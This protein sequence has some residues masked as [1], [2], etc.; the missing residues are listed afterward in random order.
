MEPL[1]VLPGAGFE[2]WGQVLFQGV[3]FVIVGFAMVEAIAMAT[4]AN[5]R[6]RLLAEMRRALPWAAGLAAAQLAAF[7]LALTDSNF[8]MLGRFA[9]VYLAF[10]VLFPVLWAAGKVWGD[11]EGIPV[12]A[13]AW[14]DRK[15]LAI[16]AAIALAGLVLNIVLLILVDVRVGESVREM[17]DGISPLGLSLLAIWLILNAP[18]ME[19]LLMRHYLVARIAASRPA[20]DGS[21]R[22]WMA[23]AVV[24]AAVVFAVG[25]AGHMEPS[26]PKLLQTFVWGLMLGWTRIWMGTWYAVA[27]HLSW[28]MTAPIAVPF[29]E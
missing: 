4:D 14:S 15:K 12:R 19:E 11:V 6:S 21:R 18:W 25:H 22:R 7:S 5:Q 9:L 24:I 10:A 29:M 28:N 27:L 23:A 20:S 17:A 26:W 8:K 13:S 1:L 16:T 3:L 2:Q